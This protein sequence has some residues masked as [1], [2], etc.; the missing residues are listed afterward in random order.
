MTPSTLPLWLV[1]L[2]VLG[3]ATLAGVVSAVAALAFR[4]YVR[5]RIPMGVAVL[6]GTAAVAI[7]LNTEGALS[8]VAAGETELLSLEAVIFNTLAFALAVAIAAATRSVGDRLATTVTAVAGDRP[9]DADVGQLVRTVGRLVSV[10]LPDGIED[11]PG[12]DPVEDDVK[13]SLADKTLLF[14]R[15]VSVGELETRLR[16]RITDDYEVGYVDVEVESDGS[17]EHLAL[18]RRRAGLGPTLVPGTAAVAVAAD[19]PNAAS[20]GDVVQLW[21]PEE[22][23]RAVS[24]AEVRSALDDVVTLALDEADARR[25]AGGRYRLLTLP[26][27]PAVEREF[28]GLLGAAEETMGVVTVHEGSDLDGVRVGDVEGTVV[29]LAPHS[30]PIEPVPDVG[31][32]FADGERVYLVGTPAAIRRAEAAGSP[33]DVSNRSETT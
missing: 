12:Y 31:R 6:V 23:E 4:W 13:A 30:G 5:S 2:R 29:A 26:A 27:R 24:G 28:A 1:T 17:V 19:P 3:L 14:P 33:P 21:D 10:T 18:G 25:V 16:T 11:I 20:P 7:Y 8:Q 9:L 15:G 32:T 22:G